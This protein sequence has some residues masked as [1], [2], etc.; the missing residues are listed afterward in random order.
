MFFPTP[1][2]IFSDS[3]DLEMRLKNLCSQ[4]SLGWINI[5]KLTRD[6][7]QTSR[8]YTLVMKER[9]KKDFLGLCHNCVTDAKVLKQQTGL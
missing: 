1:P 9:K 4:T 5:L 7:C 6:S 8:D 2:V 3:F